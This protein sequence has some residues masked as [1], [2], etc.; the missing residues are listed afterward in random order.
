MK[1]YPI[2]KVE[3]SSGETISYRTAGQ[4]EVLILIHGNMSSS[5]HY[6]T[7]M[8]RLEDRYC[9]YALDLRGFGNSTYNQSVDCL[10]DFAKDV[11]AFIELMKLDEVSLL[12]WSTGGGVVLEIA[13]ELK[14]KVRNVFLLSSVGMKGFPM[15]A[16]DE[17]LQLDLTRRITTKE[18]IEQDPLQV[19]PVLQAYETNNR[20]FMK[21]IWTHSIYEENVPEDSEFEIYIDDIMKQ[22]NLVDVDYSL[23]HFNMSKESNGVVNGN[24]K[25]YEIDSN[26]VIIHGVKDKVVP[27]TEAEYYAKENPNSTLYLLDNCGHAVVTDDLDALCNIIDEHMS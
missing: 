20:E 7:L 27:Y 22:R 14:N 4:G 2:H 5:V 10:Y 8:E 15:F 18:E 21:M 1:N 13:H 19:V 6:Q 12:G 11:L 16:K 17:N 23:V 25:F 9:I 26:L 3:L 24:A